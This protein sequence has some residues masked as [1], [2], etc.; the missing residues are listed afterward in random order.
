MTIITDDGRTIS[1]M[2]AE[3]R[4]DAVILRE[5]AQAGK[6]VTISKDRIEQRA[7]GRSSLMPAGLVNALAS[8]QQFLDLVCYLLEIAEQGPARRERCDPTHHS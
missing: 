4:P 3:D 5:P 6:L 7:N 8:R 2:V 1:G